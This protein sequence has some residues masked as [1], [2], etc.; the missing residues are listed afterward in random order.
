MPNIVQH[1]AAASL[2]RSTVVAV[3][4]RAVHIVV[5]WEIGKPLSEGQ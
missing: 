4:T 1:L 5:H 2:V 3:W